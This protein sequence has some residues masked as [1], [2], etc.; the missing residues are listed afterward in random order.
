MYRNEELDRQVYEQYK[1]LIDFDP[2]LKTQMVDDSI[3]VAGSVS[4]SKVYMY[5]SDT[6]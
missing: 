5:A 2:L 1:A 4:R 3:N 6:I